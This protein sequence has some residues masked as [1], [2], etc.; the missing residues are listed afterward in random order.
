M[1]LIHLPL[2][3]LKVSR[4]NMRHERKHPDVSDLLPSIR[5][6]GIQQPLLVRPTG[7]TFEI[8][9]VSSP[10]SMASPTAAVV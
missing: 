10:R 4:L 5:A 8:V 2:D 9:A 6:R 3:Q 1:Q 7:D